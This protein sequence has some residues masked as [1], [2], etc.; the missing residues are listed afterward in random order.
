MKKL[1]LVLLTALFA[2]S[3]IAAQD[4]AAAPDTAAPE[5]EA[6]APAAPEA[7]PVL[8]GDVFGK[9]ETD[10]YL[11]LSEMGQ[12][13]AN[14]LSRHLEALFGLYDGF[15]RY[16]ASSLKAK[17]NVRE[18]RD[19]SGFDVYMTQIVGQ[20]KDDF[21]YLHYPSPERSELLLFPKDEPDF[22]A[23]LAHQGF[24]QFIKAFVP[25]PPLWIREGVAVSFESAKWDDKAGSLD[26]PENL[27]WLETVKSLKERSLLMPLDK[28][29]AI[30]QDE[31]RAELDV[32]YPQSWAMISFLLNSKDK[33]YNRLLWDSVASLKKD[34]SLEDNQNAVIRIMN[35]WYG[36]DAAEKAFSD[37]LADRRTFP[38]LIANGVRKYADKS[39][40]DANDAFAAAQSMNSQSYVPDYYL[41]LIAYAQNQFDVAESHY[42]Q[43][44][45]L[46]CDPAITNYALGVNAYAQNRLDDAKAYLKLAKEAAPDRYGEKVDSLI[47]KIGK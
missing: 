8:A 12:D 43:A 44:L 41:G 16:D 24:V 28:L 5:A 10:H 14:A 11:V 1:A 30:G 15:F 46:G 35:T 19:K 26:F 18:F 22:S 20:S 39:W 42:K 47:A 25:N 36:S 17:L 29:L 23:S 33:A 7:A 40:T 32:F 9:A 4:A 27:A 21:V 3:F 31:A 38:E 13:R 34:G 45:A 6:A 37:Y 2:V